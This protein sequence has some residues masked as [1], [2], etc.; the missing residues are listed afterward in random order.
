MPAYIRL[1]LPDLLAAEPD[2]LVGRL[3]QSYADDGYATQFT[4]QIKA[5]GV[6]LPL[7]QQEISDLLVKLPCAAAWTMLLEYP[8]YRLRRRVDAVLLTDQV[9]VVVE[10]KVGEHIFR[11]EDVRQAEEYALDLRDFHAA[12]HERRMLPVLWCT[13][14]PTLAP[15]SY[16]P[17][18]DNVAQVHQVGAGGLG[19]L[20]ASLSISSPDDR[21]VP[22]LWDN[23]PYRPIPN[24]IESTTALFAN[25][26]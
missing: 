14:A 24:I 8:L 21:I 4:Q 23:A 17:G 22:E 2:T 19:Q 6:A 11:A 15:L 20:F 26:K 5:W 9:I 25:H 3:N 12:S 18:G 7:L 1:R 10:M 13:N 16:T